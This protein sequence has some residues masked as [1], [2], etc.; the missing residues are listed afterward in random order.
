[1]AD[2]TNSPWYPSLRLYRQLMLGQWQPVLDALARGLR[3][4]VRRTT[5]EVVC[6]PVT[7]QVYRFDYRRSLDCEI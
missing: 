4:L 3:M 2:R 5:K 6:K 1:M 7:G